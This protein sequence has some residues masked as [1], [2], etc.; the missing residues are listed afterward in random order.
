[1]EKKTYIIEGMTCSACANRVERVVKKLDGVDSAVVNF[2][3]EKLT[4]DIDNEKIKEEEIRAVVEKAGYKLLRESEIKAAEKGNSES[5]KLLNRFIISIIFTVPLLIISMGHMVGMPLPTV[6]D[7]MVNPLNFALIQLVLTLAVMFT[8][9]KFY[10]VGIKN[11]FEL[12]PNMDSLIAVGT[13][14]AFAYGIF[15]IYKII[16]GETHY[17]MHLYFESAATILTLIT[18]GKFLEAVSKG[19]TSEAIKALMGLSPKI[20]TVERNGRESQDASK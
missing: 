5:S 13:F 18:L 11:L 9:I 17:A 19:K 4:V 14:S 12:S 15:A 16:A 1:M 2:A 7:P 8:G 3:T 10:K 20:A 6:I